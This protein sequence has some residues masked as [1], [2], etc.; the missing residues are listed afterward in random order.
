VD[1]Q[2]CAD[3]ELQPAELALTPFPGIPTAHIA[4]INLIRE[5][6]LKPNSEVKNTTIQIR[7]K[8]LSL[9][10]AEKQA[11]NDTKNQGKYAKDTPLGHQGV[12]DARPGLPRPTVRTNVLH[13]QPQATTSADAGSD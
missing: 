9:E 4:A 1:R 8:D 13:I 3:P 6:Y 11:A 2:R 5:H 12:N 10:D 7:E